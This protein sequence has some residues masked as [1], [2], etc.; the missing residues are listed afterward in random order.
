MKKFLLILSA[1]MLLLSCSIL[2][3]NNHLV[4]APVAVKSDTA[5]KD[6]ANKLKPYGTVITSKAITQ[7]GLFKVH[8]IGERWFFEIGDSV[9]E[10]DMLIVNRVVKAAV[11]GKTLGGD[12]IAQNVIRL[13]RGGNNKLYIRLVRF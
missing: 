7:S 13:S 10:K 12:E 6:T 8:Q 11:N 5:K 4:P 1:G 3:K 9:L 2:H